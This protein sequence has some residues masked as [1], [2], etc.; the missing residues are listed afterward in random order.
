M[1]FAELQSQLNVTRYRRTILSHLVEY[2][3]SEFQPRMDQ[4][5]RKVLLTD[6]KLKVPQESF[7]AVAADFNNLIKQLVAD[8]QKLLSSTVAVTPPEEPKPTQPEA[9]T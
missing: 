1:T 5:A 8:E 6:D 4:Q 2:L 9:T 3:D 7:E